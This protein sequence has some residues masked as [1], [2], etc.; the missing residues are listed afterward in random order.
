MGMVCQFNETSWSHFNDSHVNCLITLSHFSIIL[1]VITEYVQFN[2]LPVSLFHMKI[3]FSPTWERTVSKYNEAILAFL[4]VG[5]HLT[6]WEIFPM[7]I[8]KLN[9]WEMGFIILDHLFL[10][11]SGQNIFPLFLLRCFLF[12]NSHLL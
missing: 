3:L 5:A 10:E 2:S 1:L 8:T 9:K 4:A 6:A 7:E 12:Y 11:W